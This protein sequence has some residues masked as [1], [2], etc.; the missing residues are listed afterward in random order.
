MLFRCTWPEEYPRLQVYGTCFIYTEDGALYDIEMIDTQLCCDD[1]YRD[2]SGAANPE[3]GALDVIP[4]DC[5]N[6]G[7]GGEFRFDIYLECVIIDEK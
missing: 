3:T 2:W 1:D 4:I 7:P 5:K 6:E